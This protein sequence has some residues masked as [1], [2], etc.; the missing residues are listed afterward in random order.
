MRVF[1][2]V[3]GCPGAHIAVPR[4]V[5]GLGTDGDIAVPFWPTAILVSQ[6]RYRYCSCDTDIAVLRFVCGK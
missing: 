6:L 3:E 4:F 1:G 2:A 5:L